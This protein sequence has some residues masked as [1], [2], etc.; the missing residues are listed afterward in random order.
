M[1]RQQ[2]LIFPDAG[3]LTLVLQAGFGLSIQN[4]FV[5]R[6]YRAKSVHV[7]QGI[8]DVRF[9]GGFQDLDGLW[10]DPLL[11][12]VERTNQKRQLNVLI[13][14]WFWKAYRE[15]KPIQMQG[16]ASL[17]LSRTAQRTGGLLILCVLA[18]QTDA[19][20]QGAFNAADQILAALFFLL[21]DLKDDQA[22][23]GWYP[24]LGYLQFVD[25][26]L[27]LAQFLLEFTGFLVAPNQGFRRV[28]LIAQIEN[29]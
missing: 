18:E 20:A 15:A 29:A 12:L 24:S 6:R 19:F 28:W 25:C 9:F 13:L 4:C 21:I 17:Q 26:A 14:R 3:K 22:H 1:L 23:D 16:Q 8:D 2:R 10:C 11:Q 7:Q 27:G 5:K